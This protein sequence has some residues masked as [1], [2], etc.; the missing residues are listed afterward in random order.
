ME[1][2]DR[3]G[4]SMGARN[5]GGRRGDG[6]ADAEGQGALLI[7]LLDAIAASCSASHAAGGKAA[8]NRGIEQVMNLVLE[9]GMSDAVKRHAVS[10]LHAM[11]SSGSGGC[12]EGGRNYVA[13]RAGVFIEMP[14]LEGLELIRG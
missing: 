12:A 14:G 10:A 9:E 7:L 4:N 1:S 3:G 8:A 2:S 5:G 11:L 13:Q 6:Q